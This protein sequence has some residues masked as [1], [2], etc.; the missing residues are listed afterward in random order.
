[1]VIYF[2]SKSLSCTSGKA[3]SFM[4]KLKEPFQNNLGR[5]FFLKM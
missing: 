1:M 2:E 5:L 3:F 4:K